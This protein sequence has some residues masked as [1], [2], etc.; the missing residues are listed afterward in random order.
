[1]S[2]KKLFMADQSK[3]IS[4][5]YLVEVRDRK[6]ESDF[7]SLPSK[8]NRGDKNYIRPLDED[9][10]KI[11]DPKQNKHFRK[12]NAKRWLLNNSTNETIG[13][14]AAFY[15]LTTLKKDSQP[16]GG[17]GFFDCINEQEAANMLFDAAKK[18]LFENGLEAMDGPINFG[19]REHFWGCLADGFFEPNY[20]MPYNQPYYNK[21]FENYGFKNYF[22]Q[23]T[24]HM[25]LIPGKMDEVVY[26]NGEH[27]KNNPD[28]RFETIENI[29]EKRIAEDFM[30]IFNE[31]WA[32]FPGIK[33]FRKSQAENVFKKLRPVADKR[34]IIFSYYNERPIAF[35]VMIP[36]LYQII[37]KFNGKF[38]LLNKLRL[39]LYVKTLKR[40]TKLIGQIFGVV[41]DFQGKGVAAGM[42]LRFEKEVAKSNFRY[43]DLEMNWIGDFNPGMMKLVN[44]I[45]GKIKKTHITYRYLFDRN[46][47]F[48]RAKKV[49]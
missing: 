1:M 33:P 41:P 13:R 31:A 47:T 25:K 44:Q 18:W 46:A 12:G 19:S 2:N 22:N 42:I 7:L 45:G 3:T 21:L 32:R 4:Q 11:F 34:T 39:L 5:F 6:T 40:N 30:I 14:I 23:Y 28:Y 8:I 37:K 36:D 38:N 24:Y 10:K 15:D 26:K 43:E 17:C 35:F 49:S 48:S 27:I 20:N 9:V 16:T 29:D